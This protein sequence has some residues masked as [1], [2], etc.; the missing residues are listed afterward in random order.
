MF[1]LYAIF[2]F[3]ILRFTVTLFNFI[4][5]PKLT[6]AGKH[7][8]DLVSILIPSVNED[9]DIL[10]LLHSLQAQDYQNFEVLMSTSCMSIN[11]ESCS[12]YCENDM[13][14]M[15]IDMPDLPAGWTEKN[16]SCSQLSKAAHG[17]Y[18]MFLDPRSIIAKGLINNAVHRMKIQRLA[19]LSLFANQLML[20]IGERLTVPLINYLVLN[21]VPLRLIRLSKNPAFSISSEQ[22][23]MFDAQKYTEHHWHEA[24]RNKTDGGND[25]MKMVKSYGY[26]AEVLLANGHQY[27]R[28]YR[29][30]A[31]AIHGLSRNIIAN[32]GSVIALCVY[33]FLVILGP[34]AIALYMDIQ[35]L[36]FA[37]TLIVLSRI[38]TSLM[39]GQNPWI[40]VMLHPFQIISLVL[41]S[42]MSVQKHFTKSVTRKQ[43][44]AR[45]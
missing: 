26:N 21:M 13:R 19:L 23:M 14:F 43:P 32:F 15:L 28:L 36:L 31:E 18:L 17:R 44:K 45:F 24:I 22:F 1:F 4:S 9:N 33:I 41:I 37:V 35:L 39:S 12:D 20:S 10:T 11:R 2:F 16:F 27:C 3:L 29:G 8:N 5:N 25:V 40:T 42:V 34:V 30:F 7:H 6:T 38:M